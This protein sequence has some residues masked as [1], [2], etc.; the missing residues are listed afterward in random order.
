MKVLVAEDTKSNLQFLKT[1]ITSAGFDV[2]TARDGEEALKIFKQHRPDLILLDVIMQRLSGIEVAKRIRES[3]RNQRRWIPII[4]ISAMEE[5][6]DVV[7][8]LEVGGDDYIKK[9]VSQVV[10]NAKL[11]A[12]KRIYDMQSELESAN[13]EL[14]RL[15]DFDAL[16][17][18][19]NRRKLDEQLRK[20]WSRSV[21]TSTS[22]SVSLCDVDYF[23][24]YNDR[25]GHQAGDRAL[26][27]VANALGHAIRRPGD[28]LARYG[29]EEFAFILPETDASGALTMLERAR[30]EVIAKKIKHEGSK[31]NDYISISAGV[32]S[33]R[34]TK[35][36][37]LETGIRQLLK[38]ADIALYEA[39]AKGRNCVVESTSEMEEPA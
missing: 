14:R 18:I 2:V 37:D 39:K 32:A 9:P 35:Q 34:P 4:F 38:K 13:K 3:D 33:I 16:T 1:C 24:K 5:D 30:E 36:D 15:T 6:E 28:L 27:E 26:C 17:G 25:Y 11:R 19:A 29:G 7:K 22:L 8:G 21:R 12:T 31:I 10:L 23:K 20:E